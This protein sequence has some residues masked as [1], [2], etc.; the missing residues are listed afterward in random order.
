MSHLYVKADLYIV[1]RDNDAFKTTYCRIINCTLITLQP[2]I[3]TVA[4]LFLSEQPAFFLSI[5]QITVEDILQFE[6]NYKGSDEERQD[7]IHLYVQH[8]GDMDAITASALCCTQED[9]P[10]LC[11]IIQAAIKKGDVTAFPAFTQESDKKKRARRKRVRIVL[12]QETTCFLSFSEK[13]TRCCEDACTHLLHTKESGSVM[14]LIMS[15]N[16]PTLIA[17]DLPG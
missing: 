10:R 9:E 14:S 13:T 2:L 6:T 7:L 1:P 12:K 15:S 5:S 4:H 3:A 8:Q 11:G 17:N 16:I